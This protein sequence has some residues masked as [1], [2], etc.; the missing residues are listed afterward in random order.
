EGAGAPRSRYAQLPAAGL[1]DALGNG[2]LDVVGY[3]VQSFVGKAPGAFGTR[4]VATT[5]LAGA[6]AIGVEFLKLHADPGICSGDSGGPNL[7]H[8]TDTMVAVTSFFSRNP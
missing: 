1:A 5:T 3:G 6:G 4:R 8:G 7:A 2:E